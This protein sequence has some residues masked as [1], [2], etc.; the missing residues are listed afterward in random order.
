MKNHVLIAGP[1]GSGKTTLA[2]FF[3]Q[4]GKNAIDVDLSGVGTWIDS[5]KNQVTA[6]ADLGK[7]INEWAEDR[8]L[9]WVW[10]GD[11]LKALLAKDE[12]LFLFGG[13][14]NMFDFIGLFDGLY[15]LKADKELVL[16]RLEMRLKS[17]KSYHEFGKTQAQR[18]LILSGL[19]WGEEKARKAG[20]QFIDATLTPK[21]IFDI[22]CKSH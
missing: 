17:G 15:Y 3:K 7:G 13:S 4:Q 8:K 1:S 19:E 11:K 20:F 5:E 10:N 16:S 9:E 18:D 22:I 2:E 14:G 6:P 21:Q 12:E